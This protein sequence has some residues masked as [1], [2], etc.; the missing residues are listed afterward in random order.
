MIVV[1]VVSAAYAAPRLFFARVTSQA[2]RH[3][4]ER[5]TF[6]HLDTRRYD[7]DAFDTANLILLYA[8][9]LIAM[10]AMYSRMCVELWRSG[11]RVPAGAVSP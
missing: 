11:R 1:W 10:A 4:T 5:D 7:P 6:C 8:A 2:L 9:P 3:S